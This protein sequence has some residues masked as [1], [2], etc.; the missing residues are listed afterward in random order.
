MKPNP[1][2]LRITSAT[3]IIPFSI[4]MNNAVYRNLSI[5]HSQDI[6]EPFFESG[7]ATILFVA[8]YAAQAFW[9]NPVKYSLL[10]KV[11]GIIAKVTIGSFLVYVIAY[12]ERWRDPV[13]DSSILLLYYFAAMSHR[14]SS[15]SWCCS[16]HLFYH[17]GLHLVS[18]GS[19]IYAFIDGAT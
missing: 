14:H 18:A 15:E 7:L 10:H 6:W 1:Q 8:I 5:E 13:F 17:G 2:Y 4:Y 12:K 19:A 3:L 16:A 11:D 9:S